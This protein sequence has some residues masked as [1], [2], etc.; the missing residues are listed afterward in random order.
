M[1]RVVWH[2]WEFQNNTESDESVPSF[3]C[4]LPWDFGVWAWHGLT[5]PNA[6]V[7]AHTITGMHLCT[8]LTCF[9][10]ETILS[11]MALMLLGALVTLLKVIVGA[12]IGFFPLQGS[13][14]GKQSCSVAPLQ[15]APKSA[16]EGGSTWLCAHL[17]LQLKSHLCHCQTV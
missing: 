12:E 13:C 10:N 3:I 17:R 15:P 1:G 14:Q 6:R 4:E 11:I 2:Y 7:H 5:A 16:R 9:W 8:H